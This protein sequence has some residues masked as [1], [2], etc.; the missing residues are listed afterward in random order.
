M[1]SSRYSEHLN[2]LGMLYDVQGEDTKNVVLFFCI[3]IPH[4]SF[5]LLGLMI[6]V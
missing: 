4:I 2:E 5:S 6:K 3:C 1:S